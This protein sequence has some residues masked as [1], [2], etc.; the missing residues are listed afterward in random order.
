MQKLNTD[1]FILKLAQLDFKNRWTVQ[2]YDTRDKNLILKLKG[3]D[4]LFT[5]LY[6]VYCE[7]TGQEIHRGSFWCE[8][9]T[10]DFEMP[11]YEIVPIVY[12]QMGLDC[13]S[14]YD[15]HLRNRIL[16]A[17]NLPKEKTNMFE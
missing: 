7:L 14:R 5:P 16:E 15:R 11:G 17:M 9:L 6:A 3:S 4:H 10:R 8:E 1:S 2:P 12:A 13:A